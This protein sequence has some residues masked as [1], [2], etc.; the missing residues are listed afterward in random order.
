MARQAQKT[1]AGA[2]RG[3]RT[4]RPLQPR[5]LGLGAAAALAV[6]AWGVLVWAAISSGRSARG[7]DST[8]WVFMGL[9]SVGAA[10]CLFVALMLTTALLRKLGIIA[11]RAPHRH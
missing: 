2:R 8:A 1:R 6:I 9:A 11:E 10:A 5:L 3:E 4:R 7:G